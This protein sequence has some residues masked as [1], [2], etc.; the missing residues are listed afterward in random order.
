MS[1]AALALAAALSGGPGACVEALCGA[2]ALAPVFDALAARGAIDGAPPVHILQIGDSHSAGD[3][4]TGAWRQILQARHGGGGRGVLPPG[5]PFPGFLPRGVRVAGSAGWRVEATF[6]SAA[7][8]DPEAVFGL[9]GFRL[10]AARAG[11]SIALAAEAAAAFDRLVVCAVTGPGAGG[12]VVTLGGVRGAVSLA[13]PPG[14]DCETFRAEGL[15]TDAALTTQDGPVTLLSWGSF[16]PGGVVVSNLG[17]VGAQLRH[18]AR[19]SDVALAQELRAYAPDLIVLAFGTNEGF[20]GRFDDGAFEEELRRQ[21][22][23]LRRLS[24]GAPLLILGAPDAETDRRALAH[25]AAP[26]PG[27]AP[28]PAVGGW[29]EP[30]ALARVRAIQRRVAAELGVAF[31]DWAARM[32]GPGTAQDWATREPPLMRRDRVH[33]TTEGGAEIARRLQADLDAAAAAP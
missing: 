20:S 22:G 9:S 11:A 30:P 21:V 29:F 15:Q 13:G 32:G 31:W 5:D 23:R 3:S 8:A 33:Y 26:L 6:G 12:Y 18:F 7:P 28:P 25:N 2:P 16:R 1:L 10:T 4:I 27:E 19:A 17:V 24:G 14:V